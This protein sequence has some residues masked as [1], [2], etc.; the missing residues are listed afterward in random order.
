MPPG[1]GALR[2]RLRCGGQL[3]TPLICSG[4]IGGISF[5]ADKVIDH[6]GLCIRNGDGSSALQ[7][8]G[9][10]SGKVGRKTRKRGF[11]YQLPKGEFISLDQKFGYRHA[12]AAQF[13]PKTDF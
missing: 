5:S 3:C 7:R 13:D 4:P 11:P 10:G 9:S 2:L 8:I 1:T 6:I 12:A